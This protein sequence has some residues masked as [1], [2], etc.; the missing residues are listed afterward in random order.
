M[1]E[2]NAEEKPLRDNL[3]VYETFIELDKFTFKKM[4]MPLIKAF[5]K[6]R[7]G[8]YILLNLSKEYEEVFIQIPYLN[9]KVYTFKFK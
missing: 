4:V 1:D 5:Y 8:E 3:I 2:I 7:V 9:L 6:H